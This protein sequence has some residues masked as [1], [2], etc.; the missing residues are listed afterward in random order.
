MTEK[1]AVYF[2]KKIMSMKTLNA[3]RHGK[4]GLSY[5]STTMKTYF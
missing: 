3:L 4:D 5:D 2:T 1:N